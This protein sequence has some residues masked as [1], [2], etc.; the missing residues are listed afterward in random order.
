MIVTHDGT[1]GPECFGCKVKSV[2]ISGEAMPT[3]G[4]VARIATK[5][6]AWDRDGEAYKRL[7]KDGVQPYG[8]DG[9]AAVETFANT[10]EEVEVWKTPAERKAS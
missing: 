6:K 7:R 3:R 4:Q 8:I 9:S 2:H 5:E 1:H 10:K